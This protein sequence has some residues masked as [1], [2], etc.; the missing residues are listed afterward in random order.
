MNAAKQIPFRI[1]VPDFGHVETRSKADAKVEHRYFY[2]HVRG[3]EHFHQDLDEKE[4]ER[5]LAA[6]MELRF[7]VLGSRLFKLQ[8]FGLLD[9]STNVEKL[10]LDTAFRS[11]LLDHYGDDHIWDLIT[12]AKE[13]TFDFAFPGEETEGDGDALGIEDVAHYVE[14]SDDDPNPLIEDLESGSI[15]GCGETGFMYGPTGTGKTAISNA[16][17][18]AIA[19]DGKGLGRPHLAD[20]PIY[21]AKAGR[22]LVAVYESQP[23]YRRRMRAIAK[24][25]GIEL[26]HLDWGIIKADLDITA[27]RDRKLFVE[28]VRKDTVRNGGKPPLLITI[29]TLPAAIGGKS[30]NDDDVAGAC[31]ILG[32][33]LNSE[34][35]S[36]VIF[37]AHPGKDESKGISGSYRWKGNSDF[38]LRTTAT[39]SGYRLFKEKDKGGACNRPIFDYTLNFIEVDRTSSGKP[40]M[41]PLVGSITPCASR[42]DEREALQ[43][44]KDG[45]AK[46]LRPFKAALTTALLDA[47]KL[48]QPYGN[49]GP[50]VSAVPAENV[51]DEFTAACPAETADSK[52]MRFNRALKKAV[53]EELICS[54]EIG[55][56]DHLWI[57]KPNTSPNKQNTL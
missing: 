25:G 45:W 34:F 33:A 1:R 38:I 53:E 30:L 9:K 50:T 3:N 2:Q 23:D 28:R 12:E 15:I 6:S 8:D 36:T 43:R 35:G 39:K 26:S 54:R 31:F 7:R 21:P 41:A 18:Q 24:E 46:S 14:F 13:G 32:R 11:T 51:R 47:G 27:E 56:I 55:G 29:D 42:D 17:N 48:V 5:R 22:V 37:I 44:P 4:V 19:E 49:E 20:G 57:T 52:R 16:L 40:V 10:M